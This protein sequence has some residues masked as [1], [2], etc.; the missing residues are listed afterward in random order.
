MMQLSTETAHDRAML[1]H[2]HDH[3]VIDCLRL[4]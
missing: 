4:H 1:E 2:A 3:G